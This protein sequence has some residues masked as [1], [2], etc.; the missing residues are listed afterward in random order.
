MRHSRM[1]EAA[2]NASLDSYLKGAR[3]GDAKQARHLHELLDKM[4]TEQET[5]DGRLW[6][7][8]HGRMLL[9]DMHRQLSACRETGVE[10]SEHVL[11]AVRLKPAEGH[12]DDPSNFVSDLRIALA[13]ANQLCQQGKSGCEQDLAVAAQTVVDKGEYDLKVDLIIEVYEKIADTVDG[14]RE[15]TRCH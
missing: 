2:I 1:A 4:L 11:D 6:L 3:R 12:W 7:T 9:A 14:F 10:L 15:M 13:V 5:E 8:D